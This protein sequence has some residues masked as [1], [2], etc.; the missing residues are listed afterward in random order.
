MLH[1]P[2]NR[3]EVNMKA[4]RK[5]I[6]DNMGVEC[7][8]HV[9]DFNIVDD[10]TLTMQI[11]TTNRKVVGGKQF[12]ENNIQDV[13][14]LHFLITHEMYHP[15]IIHQ[16][17]LQI[18]LNVIKSF[19]IM[20]SQHEIHWP[21]M[22]VCQDAFINHYIRN[23]GKAKSNLPERFY[24]KLE[25]PTMFLCN[26][27][28]FADSE[29]QDICKKVRI[30]K[31][32][33]ISLDSI[34]LVYKYT[35][36]MFTGERN[37]DGT[38]NY[39]SSK[40]EEKKKAEKISQKYEERQEDQ[41]SPKENDDN[42]SSENESAGDDHGDEEEEK[43]GNEG[44]GE[45]SG[46]EDEDE[47]DGDSDGNHSDGDEEDDEDENHSDNDDEE[48]DED[49]EDDEGNESEDSGDSDGSGS[50]LDGES[51]E[52]SDECINEASGGVDE[53]GIPEDM[54][55]GKHFDETGKSVDHQGV[56]DLEEVLSEQT[57]KEKEARENAKH[58]IG[59]G[60]VDYVPDYFHPSIKDAQAMNIELPAEY[61]KIAHVTRESKEL[62]RLIVGINARARRSVR[63]TY[64]SSTMPTKIRTGDMA[65]MGVGMTP[66]MWKRRQIG[67]P[68]KDSWNIYLDV[69]GSVSEEIP[70]GRYICKNIDSKGRGN[71]MF[72]FSS[73]GEPTPYDGGNWIYTSC[74]TSIDEVAIHVKKNRATKV[75]MCS[76]GQ[77]TVS[78]IRS[79]NKYNMNKVA[80]WE[81]VAKKVQS[82]LILVGRYRAEAMLYRYGHLFD[83]IFCTKKQ[84]FIQMR[85]AA[86]PNPVLEF[87]V[88]R[89]KLEV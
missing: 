55:S 34:A 48:G 25:G 39:S 26:N 15:F 41:S 20:G 5:Y 47:E 50:D 87:Q 89:N 28:T 37:P 36:Q 58:S 23:T 73:T 56:E 38:I 32:Y 35:Y 21:S 81:Y 62:E 86:Y 27:G 80:A 46:N 72:V 51:G 54:I 70:L 63:A 71:K 13:W 22:N 42:E 77:D 52:D 60:R 75:I 45:D 84:K 11:N 40:A 88:N 8:L 83:R 4:D 9:S 49:E 64:K 68:G 82:V 1:T 24:T 69:S 53:N 7:R 57:K 10:Q 44:D 19:A 30:N 31:S 85:K 65:M 76:D 29:V 59:S 79:I 16:W 2:L 12:I 18:L 43:D 14:D 66:P 74:G 61:E 3:K 33:M 78:D 6:M 67:A 17:D